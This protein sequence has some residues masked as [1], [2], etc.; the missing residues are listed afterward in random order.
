MMLCRWFLCLLV[1][2]GSVSVSGA[3]IELIRFPDLTNSQ[4]FESAH[5]D[6]FSSAIAFPSLIATSESVVAFL[7]LTRGPDDSIGSAI[8]PLQTNTVAHIREKSVGFFFSCLVR[9]SNSVTDSGNGCFIASGDAI[10]RERSGVNAMQ[11]L[12]ALAKATDQWRPFGLLEQPSSS[13]SSP[14]SSGDL[15]LVVVK[16]N[17]VGPSQATVAVRAYGAGDARTEAAFNTDAVE[18][19]T[20]ATGGNFSMMSTFGAHGGGFAVVEVRI[21]D[22]F[23]GELRAAPLILLLTLVGFS[24]QMLRSRLVEPRFHRSRHRRLDRSHRRWRPAS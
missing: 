12:G 23:A 13:F 7:S 17:A 2:S 24:H 9:T 3:L 21:G 18:F 1:T 19:T 5:I 22:T 6:F 4:D 10:P 11:S 20:S 8:F 16:I 15:T 14:G